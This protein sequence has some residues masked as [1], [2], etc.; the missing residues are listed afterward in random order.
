M[1]AL[2]TKIL[3]LSL[4]GILGTLAR[5]GLGGFI[6]NRFPN[7]TFPWGTLVV[8]ILGCLTI[9]FLWILVED[10]PILT[11]NMRLFSMIG[12][13]GA[14]T[15]FSTFSLETVNLMAKCQ[16]SA[17]AVNVAASVGCCLVGTVLGM[18]L[19]RSL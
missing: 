11:P 5:Y 17:A 15:T 16:W 13:L 19:A 1:P 3:V 14:F 4:G 6:Q 9:G 10:K 12:F 2:L 8:N 18:T 7:S